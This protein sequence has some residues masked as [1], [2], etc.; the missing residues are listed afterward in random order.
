MKTLIAR[1]LTASLFTFSL[2]SQA[3]TTL[4]EVTRSDKPGQSLLL[5]GSIH[6]LRKTDFPLPPEF[7]AALAQASK[8]VLES[9]VSPDH[10]AE[11]GQRMMAQQQ[12][13]GSKTLADMLSP[14]VWQQLQSYCSI[15][16]IPLEQ[17]KYTKPFFLSMV[18][19]MQHLN[20]LGFVPG[21]DINLDTQ[22][23]TNGKPVGEL[24]S[25]DEVIAMMKALDDVEPDEL[26]KSTLDDI[27]RVESMLGSVLAAW[28]SG[29]L[30]VIQKEMITE[31]QEK[32]PLVY[33]VLLVNRNQRWL[34]QIE[35]MFASPGQEL[36]VVGSAHLAGPDGLI[37]QLIKR[38]YRVSPW[39]APA[40]NPKQ[41]ST[42]S[43]QSNSE[44]TAAPAVSE[45]RQTIN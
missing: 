7:D 36:I 1:I 20:R 42:Q 44:S 18:L 24:E 31:M 3:A 2:T 32:F 11:L 28:R 29:D 15:N 26:I 40:L 9:D 41:L 13:A 45:R 5:G 33:K 16:Q 35:T 34:P 23:R 37:S 10:Q 4:F 8:L 25:A 43:A 6:L 30:S 17:L 14:K 12:I 21:V 19:T 27:N 22:A 38:G 39:Q